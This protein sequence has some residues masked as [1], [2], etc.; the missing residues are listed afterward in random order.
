MAA[1]QGP[2]SGGSSHLGASLLEHDD[3]KRMLRKTKKQS[4][5]K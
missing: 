2:A 3:I 4:I 1:S 5:L